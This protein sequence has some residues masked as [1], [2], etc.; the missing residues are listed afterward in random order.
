M[1]LTLP[2]VDLSASR[3]IRIEACL[4]PFRAEGPR[5]EA[6]EMAGKRVVHA[7]GHGGSGWS[8]SWGT[9]EEVAGLLLADRPPSA[10]VIGAGAIGLTAACV[11]AEAGI[12]VTVYAADL[13]G[14]TRSSRATGSWS[15]SSRV[16][17]AETGPYFPGRWEGWARAAFVRHQRFALGEGAAV[18]LSD[19][20]NFDTEEPEGE[21]FAALDGRLCDIVPAATRLQ[22]EDNPFPGRTVWHH[23]SMTFDVTAYTARL[24]ETLRESGSAIVRRRFATP[25]EWAE[26]PEPAI[27]NATGY[28]ARA[29]LGDDGIVP[30]RGQTALLAPQPP[31]AYGV[32][33][34]KLQFICRADG[35]VVQD[36]GGDL[37]GW[38]VED[39]TP[40]RQEFTRAAAA[41]T[42]L[43]A[44]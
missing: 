31:A 1:P 27:V 3:L 22:G 32:R 15:P 5:I 6:E 4:R 10:A 40:D 21:F 36:V 37:A 24:V 2:P 30:I 19:R 26:L 11:L 9:A 43:L 25:A 28:G 7:Y 39:E 17:V 34:G 29:L 42:A 12:P 20:F 38:G 16:A 13:P 8:L 44:P 35:V 18:T 23:R 33:A 14:E 41:L